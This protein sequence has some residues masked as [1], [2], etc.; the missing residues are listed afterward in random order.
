MPAGT[1]NKKRFRVTI[2]AYPEQAGFP[3]LNFELWKSR[4]KRSFGKGVL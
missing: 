2:S 4:T 3:V 1:Y